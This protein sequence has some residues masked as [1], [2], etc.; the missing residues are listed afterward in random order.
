MHHYDLIMRGF[1][2][3]ANGTREYMNN[4]PTKAIKGAI[5]VGVKGDYEIQ[6]GI[7]FL[8]F[9]ICRRR[10]GVGKDRMEMNLKR[11]C[12]EKLSQLVYFL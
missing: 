7:L 6:K 3:S 9:H 2:G 11:R 10:R 4:S 1:S 8:L 12:H 5:H